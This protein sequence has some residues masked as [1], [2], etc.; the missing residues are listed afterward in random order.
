MIAKMKKLTFLIYHKE[1][2]DFLRKIQEMGVLHVQTTQEGAVVPT[3]ELDEKMKRTAHVAELVAQLAALGEEE[4]ACGDAKGAEAIADQV[5]GLNTSVHACEAELQRLRKDE[6][7]LV[8]WGNFD[9]ERVRNLSGIGYVMNFFVCPQRSFNG[10]W[11]ELYNATV[12]TEEKGK[13][14][15]ITVTPVG[16]ELMLE[17][18]LVRLPRLSL[19]ELRKRIA[20]QED[21]MG[22]LKEQLA[23]IARCHLSALRTYEGELRSSIAFDQVY[24]GTEHAA[25]DRLM[26]LQGWIPAENEAEVKRFLDAQG[27]YYEIRAVRK[28]EDA[29][30]KLKNN[31][32]V[33]LYEVLTNMYGAPGKTDSDPTSVLSIFFTLFFAMCVADAGYGLVL[34]ILSLIDIK[35]K[36]KV[37]KV[38][39][40][41]NFNLVLVLGIACILVG[42]VF[43]TVFGV[44]ISRMAC[45]PGWLKSCMIVGKF[46]GTNYDNQMVL[47]LLIGVVHISLAMTVKAV[48]S[49]VF[50]GFKE[51]LSV[52]GWWLVIIG[53]AVIGALTYFGVLPYGS[54]MPAFYVVWGISAIGIYL[55]NDIHR[56]PLVNIG[57]GLYDTYNMASGLMGDILSYI[58]LYALG[59]AGGILGNTFNILA[60]M[61]VGNDPLNSSG[62]SLVGFVLIIIFGHILN[63]AMSC[64]S[65]FVHPLRLSFVEYFKNAGY[66]GSGSAYKPFGKV[67]LTNNN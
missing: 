58:R 11:V 28:G 39:F 44:D 4:K 52:W 32:L 65:A 54:M 22:A 34:V 15:F 59:L 35:T 66:E 49:T 37:G 23:T 55:L 21:R 60:L 56:N 45:V 18:E 20:A 38:L 16:G 43:G 64:L 67:E 29:P 19:S 17:A 26:V 14:Y 33:R 53:S 3:S 1:Y 13:V 9:P 57:V 6:A 50:N 61:V 36:G 8:P 51:S 30:V 48:N 42:L 7:A 12:I 40:G 41:I 25:D 46:S 5:D 47:A 27:V 63:I 10:E 2:A 31:P 24:L 62:G